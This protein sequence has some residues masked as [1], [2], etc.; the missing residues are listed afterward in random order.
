[1]NVNDIYSQISV[2]ASVGYTLRRDSAVGAVERKHTR[3]S[4]RDINT[5]LNTFFRVAGSTG[6]AIVKIVESRWPVVQI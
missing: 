6:A 3:S 2:L 4:S 1:M 5:T